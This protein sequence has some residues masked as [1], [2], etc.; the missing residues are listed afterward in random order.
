MND[1]LKLKAIAAVALALAAAGLSWLYL[2]MREKELLGRGQPVEVAVADRY[3]PAYTRVT[4][5]MLAS[6][7]IPREYLSVGAVTEPKQIVGQLSLVPFN[8]GEPLYYN[9]LAVAN[10]S[11]SSAVPEGRR[12]M[13]LPVDKISGVA[14][15]VRPGDIVDVLF[16]TELKNTAAASA[17]TLFQGVKVLACGEL[18]TTQEEKVD[19]TGSVTLA[20]SPEES[21]LALF[22]LSR[23]ILHLALRPSG[24]TRLLPVGAVTQ[25]DLNARAARRA[26]PLQEE[27]GP[28]PADESLIPKKR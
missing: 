3:I 11:L 7:E 21:E 12:A 5:H 23:G 9:K 19:N 6:R 1:P 25:A 20:L 28:G 24:D 13:T 14:G 18:Y 26:A 17:S 27:P 15:L 10:Q 4:Q 2:R 8:A 22:A 16:M